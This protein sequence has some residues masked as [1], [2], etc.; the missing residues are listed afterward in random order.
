MCG[1]V[2]NILVAFLELVVVI[3]APLL[4]VV[5]VAVVLSLLPIKIPKQRPGGWW[6]DSGG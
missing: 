6:K 2:S 4:L 1:V 3:L 5:V